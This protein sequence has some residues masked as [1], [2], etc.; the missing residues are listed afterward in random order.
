[1]TQFLVGFF[2]LVF[3]LH[4]QAFQYRVD[5]EL[6]L[7]SSPLQAYEFSKWFEA[8]GYRSLSSRSVLSNQLPFDFAYAGPKLEK[9]LLVKSGLH[10]PAE[11]LNKIIVDSKSQTIAVHLELDGVPYLILAVNIQKDEVRELLKPWLN[12]KQQTSSWKWQ[13]LFGAQAN[14]G[15]VWDC[16]MR[17]M[18]SGLAN[19]ASFIE[20]NELLQSVGRC[21]AQALQGVSSSVRNSLDFFKK[22][23]SNPSALWTEMKDSFTELKNFAL[24]IQSEIGPAMDA[25]TGLTSEQKA[26]MICTMTGQLVGSAAQAFVSGAALAKALPLMILK[27]KQTAGALAKIADLEK[28]GIFLA[29]KSKLADEVI[30][31]GL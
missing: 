15:G 10:V 21:G 31:C 28:R 11:T 9:A 1:M 27:L 29:N 2:V 8:K 17:P 6:L 5:S 12:P 4:V 13:L 24:N 20:S 14:A 23:A 16:G 19:T 26:Q 18:N 3:S 7:K 22:L 30:S 25:I